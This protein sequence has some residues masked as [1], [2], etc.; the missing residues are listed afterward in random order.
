MVRRSTVSL[1]SA[2]VLATIA[3]LWLAGGL[4]VWAQGSDAPA[5]LPE[6]DMGIAARYPGDQGIENDPNVIFAEKFDKGSLEDIF[7]R[8]ENVKAREIM[9]LSSDAPKESADKTSLLMSRLSHF[10][11]SQM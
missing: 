7:K 4:D 9:T 8:W 6:G 5:T 3:I 10:S 11:A 2:A 1:T